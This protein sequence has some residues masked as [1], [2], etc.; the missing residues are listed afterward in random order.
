[1]TERTDKK[2]FRLETLQLHA[3]QTLDTDTCSRTV[4]IYATI[5]F[6]FK[7]S[8]YSANVFGG[9]EEAFVYTRYLFTS[10][11]PFFYVYKITFNRKIIFF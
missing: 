4:P 1:M 5:S 6:A 2:N 7:S 3:G 9:K 10:F 8:E 11:L